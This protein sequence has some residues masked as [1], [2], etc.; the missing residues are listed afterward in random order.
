[1][2]EGIHGQGQ[3]ELSARRLASHERNSPRRESTYC[4][5]AIRQ[6]PHQDDHPLHFLN[7]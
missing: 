2:N 1:M 5:L 4:P 7:F 3:E 6:D